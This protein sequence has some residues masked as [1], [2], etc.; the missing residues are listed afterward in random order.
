[1]ARGFLS[2]DTNLRTGPG[3]GFESRG[4]VGRNRSVEILDSRSERNWVK[5]RVAQGDYAGLV[6]WM[7]RDN[8]DIDR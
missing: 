3:D 4:L 1:M 7:H 6:G 2:R 8:V 5:V